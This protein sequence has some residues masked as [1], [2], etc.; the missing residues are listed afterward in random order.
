MSE[1]RGAEDIARE[2]ASGAYEEVLPPERLSDAEIDEETVRK[3]RA[4][5]PP[6][7]GGASRAVVVRLCAATVSWKT[8]AS[9]AEFQRALAA[10]RPTLREVNILDAWVTEATPV[11]IFEAWA[12]G[13]Y[14]PRTLAAALH[15][16]GLQ[17]CKA[18]KFLNNFAV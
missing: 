15:R 12:E 4:G 2:K 13:A 1:Q 18:G 10:E 17:K 7:R 8:P 5:W 9:A 14:T 3:L 11:E 6:E 16:A